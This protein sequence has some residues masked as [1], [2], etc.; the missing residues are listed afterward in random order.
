[1]TE[2][3]R[4]TLRSV[5]EE[6]GVSFKTVSRVVN[7][8]SGVSPELTARVRAAVD[9][10]GYR[11]DHRAR[12]LRRSS[13]TT[14]TI[15]V[16]HNDVSNPFF[17]TILRGVEDVAA[18][19]NYLVLSASTDADQEREGR[20]IAAFM[21]RRI[22]GLIIVPSSGA[23][24]NLGPELDRGTPVVLLDLEIGD[25]E[26]DLIRSDHE[27]GA[28][29]AATHLIDHGHRRIAM[30]GDDER[31]FSARLRLVGYRNALAEA[32]IDHDP[33]LVH[34]G[35]HSAEQWRTIVLDVLAADNPPTAIFSAQNF[36][37]E[38][39][40]RTLRELELQNRIAVVGYDDLAL[41]DLVEPGITVVPQQPELL[42]RTAAELLIGRV[43]GDTSPTARILIDNPVLAR[44][45]G[46]IRPPTWSG[47]G[48]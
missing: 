46:E 5:A 45:S 37:T 22:D 35:E 16:L 12:N 15:G 20:M 32:G 18:E 1:M 40:V 26:L 33:S 31:F 41:A 38:A 27:R 36:V 23:L 28:T 19:N 4:P 47:T 21:E 13:T 34:L 29:R 6:A 2:T 24:A 42:G 30:L 7:E 43:E 25:V 8:E 14:S 9:K 10:L 3:R 17:S 44:G 39:V 48:D 11:P